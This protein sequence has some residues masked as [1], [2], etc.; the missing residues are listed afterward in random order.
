M[1]HRKTYM[2]VNF[3][4][5]RVN[6]SVKTVHTNL[7]AKCKLH[8]FTTLGSIGLLDIKLPQKDIDTD[9]RTARRTDG[10]TQ[11]IG[12]FLMLETNACDAC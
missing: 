9:G 8:K 5:N 4:Q 1:R 6:R 2:C 3:Q 12:I 11:T 10:R 7:F